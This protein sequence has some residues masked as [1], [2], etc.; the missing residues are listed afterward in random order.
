[1]KVTLIRHPQTIANERKIIY[2]ALDYPYT[3]RGKLQYNHVCSFF[4]DQIMMKKIDVNKVM[5]FSSPSL[6][7]KK[8]SEGIGAVLGISNSVDQRLAEMNFGIFEGLTSKEAQV[9]YPQAYQNFKYHFDTTTIPEGESYP[10]FM[11]RIKEFLH[12]RSMRAPSRLKNETEQYI[13]KHMTVE[14]DEQQ[15]IIVTHG[16]VVREILEHLLELSPGDSWKFVIG[17]GCIVE[18]ERRHDSYK[19]IQLGANPF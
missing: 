2:G 14:E 1:M 9:K 19:M 18:L 4:E 3:E 17:N 7:T 6:R 10:D 11:N 12:H 13:D 15:L 8:L 5:L 16:A